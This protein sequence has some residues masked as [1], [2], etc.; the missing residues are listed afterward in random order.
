MQGAADRWHPE[1]MYFTTFDGRRTAYMVFDMAD[2]SDIPPFAEP[3]F[4][5][6]LEADVE[7]A[8]VMNAQ[9]LQKG[10]SQLS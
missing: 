3:F 8:P 6:G 9:D 4:F 7:I 10:L 5:E 1:A 2:A